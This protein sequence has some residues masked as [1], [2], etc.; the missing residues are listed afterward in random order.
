MTNASDVAT[1]STVT[2]ISVAANLPFPKVDD[3]L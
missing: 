3:Y 2:K 1:Q